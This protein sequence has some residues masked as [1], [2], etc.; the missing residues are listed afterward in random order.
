MVPMSGALDLLRISRDKA[1][2]SDMQ[3]DVGNIGLV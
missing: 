3:S 2:I 1:T